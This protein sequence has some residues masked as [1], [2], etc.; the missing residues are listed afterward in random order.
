MD[1]VFL[2][3]EQGGKV[4][5]DS[6]TD[7]FQAQEQNGYLKTAS[8]RKD[9]TFCMMNSRARRPRQGQRRPICGQFRTVEVNTLFRDNPLKGTYCTTRHWPVLIVFTTR[10]VVIFRNNP[11]YRIPREYWKSDNVRIYISLTL[12]V[13]LQLGNSD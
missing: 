13:P 11:E 4:N 1:E 3:L 2:Q 8:L 5:A 12:Y 7:H 10:H 9:P 6:R